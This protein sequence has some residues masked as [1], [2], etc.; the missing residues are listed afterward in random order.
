MNV[1]NQN[2]ELVTGGDSGGAYGEGSQAVKSRIGRVGV[3]TPVG[4]FT[5]GKQ[6]SPYYDVAGL[7]DMFFTFGS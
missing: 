7:T 6:Y 3:E 1:V 4:T 2:P 5:W